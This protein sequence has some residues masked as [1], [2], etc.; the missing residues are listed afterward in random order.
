MDADLSHDP[1]ALPLFLE[2]IK[3]H[4]VVFGSRYLNGVRVCNWSFARLLLSKLSNEFIR[5]MLGLE[6]TDTTTAY[7]CF[8]RGVIEAVDVNRFRGRQNAFLIELVYHTYRRGFHAVEV[9]F[10]FMEREEGESKMRWNV[11]FE[12]LATVFRLLVCGGRVPRGRPSR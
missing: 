12:S 5:W 3:D 10:M 2:K 1:A 6:S 8:R 7:K 4:D 9:P 11:A